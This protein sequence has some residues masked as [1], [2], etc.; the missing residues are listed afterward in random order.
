VATIRG[1]KTSATPHDAQSTVQN[2]KRTIAAYEADERLETAV[3]RSTR[4]ENSSLA[5]FWLATTAEYLGKKGGEA[6]QAMISAAERA[7]R[8][9]THL[10]PQG[11]FTQFSPTKI[12]LRFCRI[13][14]LLV[15][16][17]KAKP[18]DIALLGHHA[19][20]GFLQNVHAFW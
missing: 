1:L 19:I 16:E 2:P 13:S 5:R 9:E 7:Y 3:L 15:L 11:Q 17:P 14:V 8:E 20:R 12:L 4:Y 6:R 18:I 10:L